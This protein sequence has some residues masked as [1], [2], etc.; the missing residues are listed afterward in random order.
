[1]IYFLRRFVYALPVLLGVAF[2]CFSLIYIAPGDPLVSVMPPDASEALRKQMMQIYGFDQPFLVQ[3]W[4]WLWRALHGDLGMSIA[5]SRPVAGEV[6]VAVGNSLRL[7]VVAVLIGF[8]FGIVFG[9]VS[10]YAKHSVWDRLASFSSIF[11]VSVPHYWLGM[12]LVIVF[13]VYLNWFP[14][15]GSAAGDGSGWRWDWEHMQ[16]MILPAVTMSVIPLGI[17]AR[18]IRA[19]VSDILS[20]EFM[21]GLT[22][23]GLSNAQIFMHLVKNV[24]PTALSVM[25]LQLGYLLGGSILI[26][27]V[28]SWPGAGFLLNSAVFQRDFPLLQGTI[29]IMAIFFVLLNLLVDTIQTWLDPR[30]QR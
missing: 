3:F 7:A 27:T 2:L 29:L 24:A 5:T 23:R 25:G 9:L 26:E 18:T 13:S 14:A 16:Y 11:G 15:T 1:M 20:R 19:L 12:V 21:V 22:A 4:N 17:V 30:I 10:G 6:L 8:S 28:F